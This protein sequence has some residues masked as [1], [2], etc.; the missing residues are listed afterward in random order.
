MMDQYYQNC[1]INT[2]MDNQLEKSS[3]QGNYNLNQLSNC[4]ISDMIRFNY[5]II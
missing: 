4:I 2:N 3:M 5:P 1:I